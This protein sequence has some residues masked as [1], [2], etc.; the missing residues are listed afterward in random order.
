[1]NGLVAV[2]VV[3]LVHGFEVIL[4]VGSLDVFGPQAECMGQ[5][6]WIGW[7]VLGLDVGLAIGLEVGF[8][9]G[10][11]WVC[12]GWVGCGCVG[13]WVDLW[14]GLGC[15]C[16]GLWLRTLLAGLLLSC[17]FACL[18]VCLLARGLAG[19]LVPAGMLTFSLV[20]LL[21]LLAGSVCLL[22]G[23]LWFCWQLRSLAGSECMK[24][25]LNA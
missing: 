8:L 7:T 24:L 19:L 25:G 14:L 9:L 21:V 6:V 13:G 10:C 23:L 20:C 5:C 18:L 3:G 4:A 1:M 17:S 16:A 15:A 12:G 2:F 22:V 11:G